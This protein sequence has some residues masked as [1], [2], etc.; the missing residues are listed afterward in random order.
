MAYKLSEL[1]KQ[2]N[3]TDKNTAD[4]E[5][6]VAYSEKLLEEIEKSVIIA[7]EAAKNK[8]AAVRA[9]MERGQKDSSSKINELL[10]EKDKREKELRKQKDDEIAMLQK[11][12]QH[13]IDELRKS[14]RLETEEL[15][16][17]LSAEE[18]RFR[19]KEA[20]LETRIQELRE[21]RR[22]D[23]LKAQDME[24]VRENLRERLKYL[25]ERVNLLIKEEN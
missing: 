14:A 5:N 17:L 20:E 2:L 13:E 16:R 8:I 9:D 22:R 21:L 11:S 24:K 18:K 6:A 19:L 1:E 3:K 23:Q 25:L 7:D 12:S 4:L 15:N 10:A